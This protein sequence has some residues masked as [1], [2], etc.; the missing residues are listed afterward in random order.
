[1]R[2]NFGTE[3]YRSKK[4]PFNLKLNSNILEKIENLKKT[5]QIII[6]D[7][8]SNKKDDVSIDVVFGKM[9]MTDDQLI[10]NLQQLINRLDSIIP[11]GFKNVSKLQLRSLDTKPYHIYGTSILILQAKKLK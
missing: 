9:E 3:A 1:M 4:I 11:Y 7:N 5:T 8:K 2:T 10:E 6:G